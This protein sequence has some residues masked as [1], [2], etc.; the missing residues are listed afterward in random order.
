METL[1]QGGTR[2]HQSSAAR[3]SKA[4]TS[5]R[6]TRMPSRR[7]ASGGEEQHG[8]GAGDAGRHVH[9]RKEEPGGDGDR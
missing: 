3:V 1:S 6:K 9:P 8:H 2:P 5:T 4:S 7:W